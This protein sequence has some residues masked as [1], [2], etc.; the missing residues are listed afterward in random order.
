MPAAVPGALALA[1][2]II[3]ETAGYVLIGMS[4]LTS[5]ALS[6]SARKKMQ[7]AGVED[8]AENYLLNTMS[9]RAAKP[10]I[11]GECKVGG[12]RVY[13]GTSG[14][15]NTYLHMILNLGEGPLHGIKQVDLVDQL[16]IDDKLYTEYDDLIYYEFFN[17]TSDQTVCETLNSAIPEWTD[18]KHYTA[19]LYVRVKYD[20]DYFTSMPDIKVI[21]EGLEIYNP[22][23]DIVEYTNNAAL[24]AYEYITRS[25][26]RGGIGIS[27]SRTDNGV[28]S[29]LKTAIDYCAG[30][31]WTCN[32][33]INNNQAVADNLQLIL[34]NYRGDII[35]SDNVFKFKF[36]DLNEEAVVMTLTE[37]DVISNGGESSIE[38]CQPNCISRPNAI[39]A[40]YISSEKGY[41]IDDYIFSDIAAI[42]A[43]GDYRENKIALYGLSTVDKIQAMSAYFLE[44][45][46]WNKTVSLIARDRTWSLEPMNLIMLDHTVPGWEGKILRV[47]SNVIDTKNNLSHLTCIEEN[48]VLYDDVYNITEQAWYDTTLPLPTDTVHSVINVNPSEEV[49]FYRGRSFTR[50]KIDFDA[51]VVSDYPWWDYA[52]VWVKIGGTGEWKFMTQSRGDYMIDPV[53]EGELYYCKIRSVSIYGAKEA[54]NSAYTVKKQIVGKT[55]VPSSMTSITAIVVNDSVNFFGNEVDDPDIQ[56]YEFRICDQSISSWDGAVF[57]GFNTKPSWSGSGIRSGSYRVF[58][59]PLDNSGFYSAIKVYAD[60]IVQAPKG[61]TAFQEENFNYPSGSHDNTEYYDQGA[62]NYCIRVTHVAGLTGTWTSPVIDVGEVRHLRVQGDFILKVIDASTSWDALWPVPHTW[63]T[64]DINKR[65][66]DLYG[67]DKASKINAKLK[68]G[69]ASANEY[70]SS[71][72]ELMSVDT[73]ARYYQVVITLTDPSYEQYILLDGAGGNT[74]LTLQFMR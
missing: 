20:A 57:L 70:E 72:F 31:G 8:N 29:S 1:G 12:N 71:L 2:A 63:D 68:W 69:L 16:F 51:P 24:C 60:F 7:G 22:I 13:V 40:S 5:F 38:I 17:G 65:W 74:I 42:T 34:N 49:Y 26:K 36:R 25:A 59:S 73:E 27:A 18:C 39:C 9:S 4:V 30:K 3:G 35:F 61:Y 66:Y 50:W 19:Y 53:E 10:L 52:E 44:R 64:L 37:K 48:I 21:V 54:F 56:G 47:L 58:C 41:K 15:D 28:L 67:I 11:F 6:E 14:S 46:R 55:E 45:E 62:G 33:L 32:M 23:T 43:D